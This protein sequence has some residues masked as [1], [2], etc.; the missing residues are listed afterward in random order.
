MIASTCDHSLVLMVDPGDQSI[1]SCSQKGKLM[2]K[3]VI[4]IHGV[5]DAS[6]GIIGKQ[7]VDTMHLGATRQNTIRH[8][9]CDF[10]EFTTENAKE[11]II[12]VNWS[13]LQSPRSS[14]PGLFI[15]FWLLITA[16]V[17][18]SLTK[19]VH[20]SSIILHIYRLILFPITIIVTSFLLGGAIG[21]S[22]QCNQTR[23]AAMIVLL[24]LSVLI[25]RQLQSYGSH[26]HTLWVWPLTTVFLCCGAW[27]NTLSIND[28][29]ISIGIF[30]SRAL[31]VCTPATLF[32]SA[33]MVWFSSSSRSSDQR[34]A[35]LALICL[36]YI[37]INSIMSVF[38]LLVMGMLSRF[39]GGYKTWEAA[40]FPSFDL[41]LF[42]YGATVAFS[43]IGLLGLLLPI[44]YSIAR[45]C[46]SRHKREAYNKQ[47][48]D[49]AQDGF[50]AFL[51]VMPLILLGLGCFCVVV[52][53]TSTK[54]IERDLID[55]YKTSILRILPFGAWFVGP[56]SKVVDVVGDVLFYLLPVSRP[57][58]VGQNKPTQL[59]DTIPASYSAGSKGWSDHP[60]ATRHLCL[61][62]LNAAY[63]YAL[64]R[65]GQVVVL[66]H[67]Q[68]SKIAL[69]L[70][71]TLSK[72][73]PLLTCGS[74]ISSL[75]ARFLGEG[76]IA[77]NMA[78]GWV[79]AYR[80]H[81]I[82]G[83]KIPSAS[84]NHK[85]GPPHGHTNY[86]TD[87]MLYQLLERAFTCSGKGVSSHI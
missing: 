38:S 65:Y 85:V 75:Y 31:L 13:D 21:A 18:I 68:G 80:S 60:S 74:P 36:P 50:A 3:C 52:A 17:D 25:T 77:P 46:V 32:I 11:S 35:H 56:M 69:D 40:A 24:T 83:G 63:E 6:P 27:N 49:F 61:R 84:S 73:F 62:R 9:G 29:I 14:P 79:N 67:S 37:A 58:S 41:R 20:S 43:L 15:H 78:S 59:Q 47:P 86:W 64:A 33:M 87:P 4:A 66:A 28:P 22:I 71:S 57:I 39:G 34:C 72:P 55:I 7:I 30:A 51:H 54:P 76:L 1:P 12:E 23:Q 8:S 19:V 2:A 26:Y 42:E 10:V 16:M 82:I 70:R 45:S 48:A 81:D 5:G 53:L 44:S